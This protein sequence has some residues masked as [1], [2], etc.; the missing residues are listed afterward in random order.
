MKNTAQKIRSNIQS[1]KIDIYRR[2]TSAGFTLI[3]ILV[4][5]TILATLVGGVILS[6]NPIAQIDKSQDAQRAADLQAV[7]TATDLYYNDHKCYPQEIPFG[8]EWRE[9]NTVY[10]KK[11]PQD[12]KCDKTGVNCYRYRTDSAATCPQWN[13]VFAQLSKSSTL[14]NT[15][16]LSSLS[17]CAPSGYDQHP[18]ACTLSGAVNCDALLAAASLEGGLETVLPTATPTPLPSSTPTPT[19]VPPNGSGVYDTLDPSG[20]PDAWEVTIM[21]LYQEDGLGQAIRVKAEDAVSNITSVK[22]VLYSDG[23]AR[24]FT[25]DL[26]N[27]TAQ[28]GTWEGAWEVTDTYNQV[29]G[30]QYGYDITVTDALGNVDNDEIRVEF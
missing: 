24:T 11:V 19:M 12:P 21:P 5:I 28:N 13:V 6:L 8:N 18:F 4:A 16:A 1:S 30:K 27:G 23:D 29:E 14:T 9:N 2:N 3:E 15:C 20:D 7:K 25:L 22:V 10:M 26:K 17:S